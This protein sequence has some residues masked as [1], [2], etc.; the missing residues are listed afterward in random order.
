MYKIHDV[1]I[2]ARFLTYILQVLLTIVVWMQKSDNILM[3]MDQNENYV[4]QN[5][6]SIISSMKEGD[7]IILKDMEIVYPKF[8]DLFN[9]NFQKYGN[10]FYARIVLD[11]TTSERLIVHNDFRC[12][13]L[14]EKKN[15]DKQ[16]PPFLNRFEKHFISFQ[17]SKIF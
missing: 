14:L 9:K 10:S 7:I 17:Y 15:I 2:P 8:Y 4:L 1:L 12:I 13:I 16:D 5:A 3:S 11:S 6:W